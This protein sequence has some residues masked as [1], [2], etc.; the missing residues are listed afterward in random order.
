M[1]YDEIALDADPENISEDVIEPGTASA[2]TTSST[3][4]LD[5]T[6]VDTVKLSE[7]S[8]GK[9]KVLDLKDELKKR[10]KGTGGNIKDII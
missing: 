10:G 2:T 9:L 3:T 7:E 1:Y 4:T 6:T 5:M 8:A